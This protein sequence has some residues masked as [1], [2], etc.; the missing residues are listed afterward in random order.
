MATYEEVKRASD[1]FECH[2]KKASEL[3]P[4][5][6]ALAVKVN[7]ELRRKYERE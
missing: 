2:G 4:E 6:E 3:V 5:L 1:W 7:T